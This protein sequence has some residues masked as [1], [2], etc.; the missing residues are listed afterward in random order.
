MT[1]KKPVL[2]LLI[3]SLVLGSASQALADISNAAVLFLRIAAGARAAGM[4]EAFVA[5][6]DDATTTHW[7]PAGLGA[8]PLSDAW[9]EANIPYEH[10]PL[11]AVAAMKTGGRENYRSYDLWAI[12]DRG[13]IRWDNRHWSEVEVFGTSSNETVGQKVAGYFG[14]VDQEYL[15]AATRRVAV[16]NNRESYE[17]LDSLLQVILARVPESYSRYTQIVE[18]ADSARALYWECRLNWERIDEVAEN[19]QRGMRDETMSE[20]ESDRINYSLERARNR[21]L[22]EDL[23]IPYSAVMSGKPTA[24]APVNQGILVGSEAGLLFFNGSR[25]Q[26]LTEKNGLPSSRIHC[27]EETDRGAL[28]GTDNGLVIFNGLLIDTLDSAT[29]MPSGPVTAIGEAGMNKIFAVID[30]DLW[31]YDGAQWRNTFD[32]TVSLD[33]N[34]ERI[35]ERLSI[36]GNGGENERLVQTITALNPG[37]NATNVIAA[38]QVIKAPLTAGIRGVVRD[39][40]VGAGMRIWLGTDHGV[41]AFSGNDWSLLGY[42]EHTVAE[43]ETMATLLDMREYSNPA[44]RGSYEQSLRAVND[45]PSGDPVVGSVV[46]V[47]RD[48][49]ASSV[50]QINPWEFRIFV[51]TDDGLLETDGNTWGRTDLKGLGG[52]SA[53]G[54]HTLDNE[55][56]FVG[57]DKLVV[58]AR[59]RSEV[60]LMYAKWLPELSDDLHYSFMSF[61]SGVEGWGT[62]GLNAT[63]L[64][65]GTFART[66]ESGPDVI[67]EFDSYDFALTG[68]FG[69]SLTSN[70]KGG[71]SAKVIYSKLAPQ[72][73]GAEKG[74]GTSTGFALDFGILYHM[75]PRLNLGV[76]VTNIGPR[77]AYLDAAQSDDLPRNLAVGFKYDLIRSEY[78]RLLITVEAN[79]LLVGMGDGF[80]EE[81]KQTV[82]N[83]GGEFSY[84]NLLAVRAGYYYDEEGKIKTPTFGFGVSPL[85]WVRVDFAYIPNNDDVA[86]ANTLRTS[87]TMTL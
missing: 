18:G 75:S 45:I 7:N 68:S 11:R 3:A 36:Y 59:G 47:Y 60:N 34:V 54:I 69:T 51:A 41:L 65:Y 8:H 16:A 38:G 12:S 57:D 62:F 37:I 17:Y 35:A 46:Y 86:L 56:W 28:V 52:S 42:R 55:V 70:L 67:G 58:L 19:L 78:N 85:D 26:V 1:L 79:K 13:L 15:D 5:V 53:R 81:L 66:S 63:L 49:R 23:R 10:R 2:A 21:F 50:Y 39:I 43:G 30:N 25:W 9:I 29:P 84:M 61:T 20:T 40:Y 76:A 24:I 77:M 27:I 22:P 4:G 64:Y 6:A 80:S 74:E 48:P 33:E 82:F 44:K 87:F 31:H 32:Y 72:G 83:G 73:A 14:A 71:V